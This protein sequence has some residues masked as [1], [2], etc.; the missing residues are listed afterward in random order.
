MAKT[1]WAQRAVTL[2]TG[3]QVPDLLREMY[4]ERRF[5]QQEIADALGVHRT[6]VN[7]WLEGY[8]ISRADRP[9]V[10]LEASA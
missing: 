5:T 6:T 7:D 2:R 3:R 4:V 10:D 9:P 8:G 1:A